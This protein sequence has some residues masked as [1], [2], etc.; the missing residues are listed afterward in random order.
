MR[1]PGGGG[2][3]AAPAKHCA[4]DIQ[5][6]RIGAFNAEARIRDIPGLRH[7]LAKLFREPF[8]QLV[9]AQARCRSKF[10]GWRSKLKIRPRRWRRFIAYLESPAIGIVAKHDDVANSVAIVPNY[11]ERII[12]FLSM[13]PRFHQSRR[14]RRPRT[15]VRPRPFYAA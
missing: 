3:S 13:R 10:A 4:L 5:F 2:G 14:Q 1:D 11:T 15:H 8:N 9:F 7:H 6:V 12:N